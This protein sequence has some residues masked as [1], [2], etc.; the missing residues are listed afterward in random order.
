MIKITKEELSDYIETAKREESHVKEHMKRCVL[1]KKE[2]NPAILKRSYTVRKLLR[3]L[4]S[5]NNTGDSTVFIDYTDDLLIKDYKS[6]L[7]SEETTL[8]ILRVNKR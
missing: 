5:L 3:K 2:I 7:D 1:E 8:S 6:Y 4:Y